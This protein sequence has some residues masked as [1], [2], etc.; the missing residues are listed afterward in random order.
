MG[1]CTR[2]TAVMSTAIVLGLTGCSF[3][4][5]YS[6]GGGGLDTEQA[7]RVIAAGI[8]EQTG[9]TGVQVSCP[10]DVPMEQGNVFTCT[11]TTADGETGTVTVTQTDDDGNVD[12]EVTS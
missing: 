12:W 9:A 5:S 8:E 10:E 1:T 7:E 4:S 3:N 2:W 6:I 11:A